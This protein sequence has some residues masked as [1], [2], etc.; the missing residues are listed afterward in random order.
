[1]KKYIRTHW[2][3]KQT[4]VEDHLLVGDYLQISYS[5]CCGGGQMKELELD[6]WGLYPPPNF[7]PSFL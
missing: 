5:G 2:K 6:V 3:E 4:R 7:L 1:M